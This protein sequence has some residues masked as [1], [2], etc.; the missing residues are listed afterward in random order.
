MRRRSEY[1]RAQESGRRVH[2]DSFVLLVH[3]SDGT[4]QL[5]ITVTKRVGV[6]VVRNRIKRLVRETFRLDREVF[7]EACQVVVIARPNAATLDLAAV[8]AELGGAEKSL[9]KA[10]ARLVEAAHN[11]RAEA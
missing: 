9:R 6:A 5:G 1:L 10:A 8:R 2:T 11:T 7:P 4:R 3:G